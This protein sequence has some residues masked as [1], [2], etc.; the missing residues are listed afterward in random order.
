MVPI[1]Y[2]PA[3]S[4]KEEQWRSEREEVSTLSVTSMFTGFPQSF[5]KVKYCGNIFVLEV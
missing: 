1:L 3:S 2:I 4:H 5:G